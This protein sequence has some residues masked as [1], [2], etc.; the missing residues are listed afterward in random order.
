MWKEGVYIYGI[1]E[2]YNNFPFL[3]RII[4]PYFKE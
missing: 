1:L 3:D 4:I 2:V